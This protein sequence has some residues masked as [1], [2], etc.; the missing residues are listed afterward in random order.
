MKKIPHQQAAFIKRLRSFLVFPD[1]L[2][3]ESHTGIHGS[4]PELISVDHIAV[5]VWQVSR[6]VKDLWR[7]AVLLC[8]LG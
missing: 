3:N 1:F 4:H 5:H 2:Q 6:I 8:V 7:N